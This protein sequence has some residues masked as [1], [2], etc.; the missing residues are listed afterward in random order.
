M[1]VVEGRAAAPSYRP[2]WCISAL[3][4]VLFGLGAMV[5]P[6]LA[7]DGQGVPPA[8]VPPAAVP[9][10]GPSGTTDGGAD[11]SGTDGVSVFRIG[12]IASAAPDHQRRLLEPFS[13]HMQ[14]VLQRPVDMVPFREARGLMGAMERGTIRYAMGPASLVAAL[15]ARCDCVEPLASQRNRD[16]GFGLFSALVAPL[17]GVVS[18][19]S[20]LS[21]EDHRLIV[22]GQ[23]SVVSH[24]VG[25]SELWHEG[26]ALRPEQLVFATSLRDAADRLASGEGDA[27]VM[28]TR[29]VEG[30]VLFDAPPAHDL[31]EEVRGNLRILWRSR[32][33]VGHS[34]FVH[35]GVPDADRAALRQMLVSLHNRDGDAFDA[36]DQGSGRDFVA[37]DLA[38]YQPYRDALTFWQDQADAP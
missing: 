13:Q 38:A 10:A 33:L 12:F 17:D 25:L 23:G 32:P 11:T 16:G 27:I 2:R 5:M 24:F 28:W 14:A 36:L 9:S 34:H 8:A 4:G 1:T 31:G 15:G 19:V 26:I 3:L 22:V 20:D 6:A 29:Q 37:V 35:T 7:Q 21:D 18:D 30:S